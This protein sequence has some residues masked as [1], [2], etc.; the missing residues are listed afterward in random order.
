MKNFKYFSVPTDYIEKI[1]GD[2][3]DDFGHQVESQIA[4]ET[5]YGPCR[6]CLRQFSPG[7]K[8]LLFSYAPVR[9]N[10]PYNEVGPVYIH[11]HCS[12][13]AIPHEFPVEVKQGRLPI[14]LVL[15]CYNSERRMI[16]A[17]QV[18]DNNEV[19]MLI[20]ELFEKPE[21]EFIHIRN[22][23]AQCFIAQAERSN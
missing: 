8:R 12:P 20:K 4:G 16:D 11:E 13:Y 5:G 14:P 15:R 1:R 21:I 7:E 9:S 22:A 18:K 2:L 19:E 23:E 6:C 17:V 3:Q 10:N